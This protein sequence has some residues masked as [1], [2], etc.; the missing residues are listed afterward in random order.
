VGK[1]GLGPLFLPFRVFI[2]GKYLL[3][4][5]DFSRSTNMEVPSWD[6]LLTES[7]N[8]LHGMALLSSQS[9]LSFYFSDLLLH[10]LLTQVL[11]GALGQCG[12]KKINC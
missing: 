9:R 1:A 3:L 6:G 11:H 5:H 8:A 2:R 12:R 10:G 7:K 4:K